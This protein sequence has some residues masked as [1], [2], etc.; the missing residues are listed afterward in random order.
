MRLAL[1]H[2]GWRDT[3]ERNREALFGLGLWGVPSFAVGDTA[4]WGQDRLWL[5][6]Q[7]L[8][9]YAEDQDRPISSD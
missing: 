1:K 7:A 5:I 2:E 3:A 4:V 9:G 8:R 6:E